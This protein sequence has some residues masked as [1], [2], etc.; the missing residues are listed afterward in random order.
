LGGGS[1]YG[2]YAGVIANAGPYPVTCVIEYKDPQTGRVKTDNWRILPGH[3]QPIP[4]EFASFRL[5][6]HEGRAL[7]LDNWDSGFCLEAQQQCLVLTFPDGDWVLQWSQGLGEQQRWCTEDGADARDRAV[8]GC[9]LTFPQLRPEGIKQIT[10]LADGAAGKSPAPAGGGVSPPP[11]TTAADAARSFMER[12]LVI[13]RSILR[14]D[15]K[16]YTEQ[17]LLVGRAGC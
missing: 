6:D 7:T 1:E 4:K 12:L 16:F 15:D 11:G 5:L 17:E 10:R 13:L 2:K 14:R 9:W 8:S 3:A